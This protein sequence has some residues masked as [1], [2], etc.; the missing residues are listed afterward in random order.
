MRHSRSLLPTAAASALAVAI[1]F[2]GCSI[3]PETGTVTV[4]NE[5][6]QTEKA[7]AVDVT[8][9]DGSGAVIGTTTLESGDTY[10]FSDIA[11]GPVTIT[12]GTLCTVATTL[13]AAKS[14]ATAHFG[15]TNCMI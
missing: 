11:L 14:T 10:S 9:T 7:Q 8:I 2:S 13:T 4:S 12:A 1:L 6:P 3:A 5:T 15:P